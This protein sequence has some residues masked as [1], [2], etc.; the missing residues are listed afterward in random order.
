MRLRVAV[1]LSSIL[2]LCS[3]V[4]AQTLPNGLTVGGYVEA[5]W[6]WNFEKPANGLTNYRAFDNRHDTFTLANVA[7]DVG[8]DNGDVYTRIVG[9]V[10]HTPSTYYASEPISPG[11][12]GVN[13]SD[14]ALWKY[15][16]QA[17]LGYRFRLGGRTATVDTGIFLSPIGPETMAIHDN[18]NWSRS[19]LFYGLP[20][21]HTGARATYEV[22]R[23]WK[24][25]L[26][27]FNGWNSVVDNNRRKSLALQASY[28]PNQVLA[29]HMLYFGGV[30]RAP[31]APEGQP[32]RHL[33]DAHASW[34]PLTALAFIAHVDGGFEVG[35]FGTSSW[36][37]GALT[38]R[39]MPWES[40]TFSV[41]GDALSER[42]A[43]DRDGTASAL[44]YP[45]ARIGSATATVDFHPA[46]HVSFRL[47]YR[48]DQASA[49][50]YSRG[51][52]ATPRTRHG[53]T[54]T[55]GATAWF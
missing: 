6:Q 3:P 45:A 37:G 1:M 51:R 27:A 55:V 15:L 46:D 22:T 25:M 36:A 30:E 7:L 40:W 38:T 2:A 43:H 11:A 28:V 39:A 13:T 52:S 9:Q 41:R 23:A 42:R 24:L 53:D 34:Q 17:Y 29:L 14:A 10:G 12:N 33:F 19:V 44:F 5:F 31:N 26:A 54:L 49:P 35:H 48:H 18:A 8:W 50:I 20:F 47:E 16:Q 4:A 32:W 21:Y